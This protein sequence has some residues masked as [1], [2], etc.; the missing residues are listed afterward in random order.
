MVVK[1]NITTV[2]ETFVTTLKQDSC[3][4]E[5]VT[6]IV[7]GGTCRAVPVEIEG[8]FVITRFDAG[9]ELFEGAMRK[10]GVVLDTQFHPLGFHYIYGIVEEGVAQGTGGGG[11]EYASGRLVAHQNRERSHVIEM[12]VR[13]DYGIDAVVG[14]IFVAGES[15]STALLGVHPGIEHNPGVSDFEQVAVSPYLIGPIEESEA[16]ISHEWRGTWAAG[17]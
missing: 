9:S 2:E 17:R 1:M 4:T 7:E 8:F 6:G 15:I 12:R 10:Q 13:Y 11:H 5:N 16:S 3:R 14:N